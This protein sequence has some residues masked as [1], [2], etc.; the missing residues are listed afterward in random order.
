MGHVY[1]P[2]RPARTGPRG[3]PPPPRR[4]KPVLP[5]F[6]KN[7]PTGPF[8]AR[9]AARFLLS[10]HKISP[11]IRPPGEPR[12]FSARRKQ[13]RPSLS[14]RKTG[15]QGLSRPAGCMLLPAR[16]KKARGI[17]PSGEPR[18]FSLYAAK[19]PV[20]PFLPEKQARRAVS[21]PVSRA[22]TPANRKKAR[23]FACPAGHALSPLAAKKPALPLARR[24]GP[25]GASLAPRRAKGRAVFV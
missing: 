6:P 14:S 21:R 20:L 25:L 9:Q 7:R 11:G 18:A 24:G 17:R 5:F 13:A 10:H 15:P 8:L 2:L 16:R 23:E 22:L 12:A 4:K 1:A 3:P 19:R